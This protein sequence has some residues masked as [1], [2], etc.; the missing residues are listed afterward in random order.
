MSR[1]IQRWTGRESRALRHALRLSVRTFAQHLGVSDRAVSKWEA[2]D[3]ARAPGPESQAILDT[4]YERA[5]DGVRERFWESL[6]VPIGVV[7]PATAGFAMV[8][9]LEP[10]LIARA[11]VLE[12]LVAMISEAAKAPGSQVITVAGPG[13]FG[14]TTLATQ[15]GH[16]STVRDAF[17]EILWVETGEDCTPARI[18]H[19][20]SDLCFHLDGTRPELSDPEQAGFHLA[21]VIGER[22][23]LL[24]VDNVWS[25]ADLAPF[26]MGAPNCVRLITTRNVRVTPSTARVLRLGPMRADQ[27]AELLQRTIPSAST[28]ALLPLAELCGGWP[29]LANLVGASVSSDVVAGSP[30]E[31]AVGVARDALRA[32]GPQAFDIWDTDQRKVAIS[33]VISATLRAL[34]ENVRIPGASDLSERYVSLAVFPPA[35]PIPLE[36]LTRWW[37]RAHGWSSVAVRQFCKVLADR[38][39][40]SAYRADQDVVVLHDVFRAYLLSLVAQSLPGLHRS[41]LEASKPPSGWLGMPP[42]RTYE[43]A[44]LAFHLYESG[45]HEALA[46]LLADPRYVI[47]KASI[48]GAHALRA[49]RDLVLAAGDGTAGEVANE[50]LRKARFLTSQGYLLY[51][52]QTEQ[53]MASTLLVALTRTGQEADQSLLG[54]ARAAGTSLPWA[55]GVEDPDVPG[56]VGTVVSVAAREDLLVS[57][58]EDGVVRLWDLTSRT[59]IRSLRGH[60]GWVHAV[61]I[62]PDGSLIASA[63]EDNAIRLWSAVDGTQVGILPG[64]DKRIRTMTFLRR[65]GELVSGAEDGLVRVWDLV[66]LTLARQAT[67]RGIG[68][69]SLAVSDD[70]ALVAA[71]GEDEYVRLLDLRTGE[72]LDEKAL[73]R[74]WVRSVMFLP[75]QPVL[76]S[77]SADGTA[78]T[79]GVSARELEP[80]EVLDAVD[81]RLRALAIW[82]GHVVTAGED[83]TVTVHSVPRQRVRMPAGV[84]WVRTVASTPHGIVTGC[85]DGG[86]RMWRPEDG[87]ALETL[88]EGRNTVW[89]AAFTGG[90]GSVALGR[91]DGTVRLLDAVTGQETSRLAAGHGRVWALASSGSYLAAACGDGLLRVWDAGQQILELNDDVVLTWAVAITEDGSLLTASDTNG[92]VRVWSLPDGELR[93]DHDAKA[94]RVR[95]LAVSA[96]ADLVA[97]AGGDG[98]VRTWTLSTGEERGDLPVPGWARTVAFDRSGSRLAVGAGNGDVYVH[99]LG[100]A[101]PSAVLRGHRGRVLMLGFS[102]DGSWLA[103]TAADGTV[104][105]WALDGDDARRGHDSVQVRVDASGQCAAFDARTA[106][107]VVGS[108]GG[109]AL[110]KL[111]DDERGVSE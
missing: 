105:R 43:W 47:G 50:A 84:N 45:D 48:C 49:D 83:A 13:G 6:G 85:E 71:S 56:H 66:S 17:P 29:L 98:V 110:L 36:V 21:R 26:L 58:G 102:G 51:G 54:I 63:G 94:G 14:K 10:A 90:D 74:S 87:L 44:N 1:T 86:L 28:S 22:H 81:E 38:S 19:L 62:S 75:G 55:S 97:A 9:N 2:D 18:T 109:T 80:L 35:T 24:V 88:A 3:G 27:V 78:R 46:G 33:Q 40:L 57:G 72:L 96:E 106:S 25:G 77:A 61:A 107:V 79:W 15:A 7:S 64:H 16:A 103:S 67:T 92:Q 52:Q 59:L 37:G 93:W 70:D 73:H 91:A 8:P 60:T 12:T 101:E 11:D 89:S 31:H 104:R 4:A 65:S 30:T 100:V 20:I 34:D 5:D 99:R 41:F 76:V 39:L 23:L 53:D 108:A 82:D 69:W 111:N 42:D 68:I 95:S 32:H